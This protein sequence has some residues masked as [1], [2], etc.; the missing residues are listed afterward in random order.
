MTEKAYLCTKHGWG[1]A[2]A[3]H[4]PAALRIQGLEDGT[5]FQGGLGR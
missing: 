2:L 4:R 3:V 1:G 5:P